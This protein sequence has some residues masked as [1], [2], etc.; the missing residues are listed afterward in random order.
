MDARRCGLRARRQQQFES[1]RTGQLTR[2]DT[3]GDAELELLG[4][5]H[6]L[7]GEVARVEGRGDDDLGIDD[8]L[9]KDRVGPLLVVGD[10]KLV[11]VVLHV[12]LEAE[13]VLNR[14]QQARLLLRVLA[15]GVE[16]AEDCAGV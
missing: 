1:R 14:A 13:L 9:G 10:D 4:R 5:R 8:L 15:A 11:A 2:A 6:D 12:L 7:L 16:D 3:R